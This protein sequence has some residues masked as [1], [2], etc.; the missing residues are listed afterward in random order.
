MNPDCG[1]G[2]AA[3]EIALN[4]NYRDIGCAPKV[5][6]WSLG[7]G[8]VQGKRDCW[9]SVSVSAGTWQMPNEWTSPLSPSPLGNGA[10]E[11]KLLQR[12]LAF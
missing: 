11:A 6:I 1:G 9:S 12:S 7:R 3:C 5:H 8:A 4:T 2:H 10:G